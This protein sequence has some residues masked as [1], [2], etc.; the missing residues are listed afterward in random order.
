M[1]LIRGQVNLQP[2]HCGCVA[3]IGN[4]DG[5][6][7]G[8]QAVLGEL[9]ARGRAS[10]L[11]STVITFEPQPLEYFAPERAPPRLTKLRGKLHALHNLGI[12]RVL[13]LPFNARLATLPAE[14]FVARVLVDGLAVRHLIVGDDFRFGA[15]G[16]GD[17]ALL[18]E[19]GAVHGFAVTATSTFGQDGERV[20][21]TRVR[22]ALAADDLLAAERLLGRPYAVFGAVR[23]G[24]RRGREIG[25][26]TA[27]I[28]TRHKVLP[29]RGVY[30]VQVAG[31]AAGLR[32]GVANIG[33]RPTFGRNEW[34]L[35]VHLFD[36]QG[37][38]YGRQLR[39]DFRH[40]LRDERKFPSIDALTAQIAADCQAARAVLDD[41]QDHASGLPGA[42]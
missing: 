6:H 30:A 16:R 2:R 28:D 11:P 13:C 36:F 12:D 29:V 3:T 24:D 5:V 20:S 14:A 19:L 17:F 18:E 34:L 31:V 22:E 32:P 26:P 27:N 40:K 8:H 35:E 4:F 42:R 7:R 25:F 9:L 38:I 37:D 41:L 21:S 23:H 15:G 39:V 10:G 1:E 33:Q